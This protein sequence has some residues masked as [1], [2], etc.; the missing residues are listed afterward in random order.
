MS[1]IFNEENYAKNILEKG[2]QLSSKTNYSLLLVATYLREQGK[3]DKEIELNLH[4]IA[5]ESFS[6]YNWVKFYPIVDLAV[7]KSKK[8]NLKRNR[9]SSW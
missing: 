2:I 7:R 4:K 3:N 6:D 9:F 8:Y 5:E 1:I